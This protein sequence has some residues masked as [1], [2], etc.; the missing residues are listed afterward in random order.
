M[1]FIC[2]F[3]HLM[4]INSFQS[5]A[6]ARQQWKECGWYGVFL[7]VGGFCFSFFCA[8]ICACPCP[9]LQAHGLERCS[10]AANQGLKK[11]CKVGLCISSSDQLLLLET[12]DISLVTSFTLAAK[13]DKLQCCSL[14]TRKQLLQGISY[15]LHILH[16]SP[17]D[18]ML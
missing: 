7:A 3:A 5:L 12:F 14:F 2:S 17:C 16:S 8:G 15:R 10:P 1:Y 13:R 11:D 9:N 4:E 18:A 6:E